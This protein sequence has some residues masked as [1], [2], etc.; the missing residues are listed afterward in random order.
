MTANTPA[1]VDSASFDAAVRPADPPRVVAVWAPGCG[2]SGVIA[3]TIR[4][5]AAEL[6]DRIR[7]VTVEADANP[8]LVEE[9]G[10]R[11]LPTLV[12][13]ADG[14]EQLRVSGAQTAKALMR[15]LDPW[16]STS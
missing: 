10:V 7:V 11:G 4:D 5:L 12:L 16:L 9:L 14:Q 15:T 1:P 8:A 13:F 3:P 6:G 2:T